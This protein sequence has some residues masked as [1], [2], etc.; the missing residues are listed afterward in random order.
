MKTT[1]A[2]FK[3]NVAAALV[4]VNLQKAL[5]NTRSGFIDKRVLAIKKLPEFDRLRDDAR[6]IKLPIWTFILSASRQKS[7]PRAVTSTGPRMPPMPEK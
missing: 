7:W 3:A 4:D 1:S 2:N 6:D 5:Q